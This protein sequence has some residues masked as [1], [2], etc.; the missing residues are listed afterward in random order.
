MASCFLGASEAEVRPR[1]SQ[2][3]QVDPSPEAGDRRRGCSMAL[4]AGPDDLGRAE[5]WART[6]L[7]CSCSGTKSLT[8]EPL[9]QNRFGH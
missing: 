2:H 1:S 9:A 8:R 5:E 3:A 6:S 7:S 4:L